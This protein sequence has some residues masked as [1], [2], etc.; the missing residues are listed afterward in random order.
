MVDFL[1]E[2]VVILNLGDV[3]GISGLMFYFFI[4]GNV[5][6]MNKIEKFKKRVLSNKLIIN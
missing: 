4:G 1:I 5:D 3:L 6:V 2:D